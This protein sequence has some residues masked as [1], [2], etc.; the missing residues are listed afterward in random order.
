MIKLNNISFSY[1]DKKI[2]EQL[3]LSLHSGKINCFLGPSGC[4][5]TSLLNLLAGITKP[6]DGYIDGLSEEIPAYIFQETRI[7]LW[8]NVYQNVILPLKDKMPDEKIGHTAEQ[9]LRLVNLWEN[10]FSYPREL[11]GGMRQRVSIARAFAYP[12]TLVLMDEAFQGLYLLLKKAL[13]Q[14]FIDSWKFEP[15]TVA[16]VTHDLDEALILGQEIFILPDPPIREFINISLDQEP[17][18]ERK[19]MK[20]IREQIIQTFH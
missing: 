13:I 9:Y 8:K 16:F 5:K 3:S 18:M 4:G 17:G 14:A 6:D 19:D 11:S 1:E 2:F 7:M 10:R 12:S 20:A 15:R